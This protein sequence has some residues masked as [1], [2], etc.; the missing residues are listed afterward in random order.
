MNAHSHRFF[1]LSLLSAAL[2]CAA[3]QATPPVKMDKGGKPPVAAKAAA[4]AEKPQFV[5]ELGG[6]RE[7]RLA[8]GLQILLFP[9]QAQ[10]TTTVN[11]TYRV[12]SRH[13]SQG[14]YGMAHLLEHLV[15]KGTPKTPKPD[16]AFKDRAMRTNGTTTVDRTN[17]FA[18]FNA[19]EQTLDWALGFEA[20]RMVNSF[21]A[22]ADLDSEMTVV[23]NEYENGENDPMGVLSRRV[24]AVANDWHPY[25]HSTI[26]PKSDIENVPIERLQGFYK[27]YYRP[28]NATLLV[29]GRFEVDKVLASIVRA[30][31][32]LVRPAAQLVE[33]YTA[34]PPQDGER[35]VVVRRV[36]GQPMLMAS[37]H[38]PSIAHPDSA[39]L[40]VL[41]L[42]MSMQPS[43]HLYKELVETKLAVGAG[44]GGLGGAAPGSTQA[45]AALAP[46]ADAAEVERKLLDLVE[47]RSGKPFE[48]SELE[49][50]REI[51]V[52]SYRQQMKHPEALIQQISSLLGAG[53]W[54]L[55]FQL[56]EDIPKVSLEDVE[57]VRQAYFKPANRTLGRYLPATEVERVAIP[58]APPLAERLSKLQGPPKVEEG[59]RFDPTVQN[60]QAR[61]KVSRLP[62]GLVLSQLAKQTRGN[63][64]QLQMK[65]RWGEPRA[66]TAAL[67]TGMID[68]LMDEGSASWDKQKLR[69]ELV[70]LKAGLDIRGGNQ[71]ATVSISAEKDTL[72][73][74]LKIAADVLQKPLLPPDAFDRIK[75]QGL[76]QMEASRQELELLRSEATRAHANQARGAVKGDPD[77][78]ASLDEQIDELKRTQL[79][80]VQRFWTE[81]WSADDA[82]IAVV[83]A[84]PAGLEAALEQAFGG[85]KKPQAP[86]YVRH[87]SKAVA[88]PPARFDVQAKDKTSAIFRMTQRFELSGQ[89]AD[90]LPMLV[91][92]QVFG[93]G[94]L[95]SRLSDRVRQKE[96]LTYGIGAS[97]QAPYFGRDGGLGIGGTFAPQNRERILAVV[98]EELVRMSRDGITEL[99]L[100][101][102]RKDLLESWR[103]ARAGEASLATSLNWFAE[104]AKDWLGYDGAL[105]AQLQKLSVAQVNA[106]WRRLVKADAFVTSTAGDFAAK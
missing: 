102:A 44:L 89:D 13:E 64:V 36:G 43:G 3:A 76:A 71:G 56:V 8:N 21:I 72:L 69:D 62:S 26:G 83:G 33:P 1:R 34:E 52:V 105:E 17:Y 63:Q 35:S 94:G 54:R 32:P 73:A 60:L 6:I 106:A 4:K 7:Y 10:S 96:G 42:L 65:L 78:L 23:R 28:D 66:T 99:E 59:E 41:S 57:R 103:Q 97:L 91:A 50:V 47:G 95:D 12:G 55:L 58:P 101:R 84:I 77:Y 74:V 98:Q 87:V 82:R 15:F 49:R 24:M 45:M 2:V 9:D 39:P 18:S 92:V 67:G 68:E 86:R 61:T 53:D 31:G 30:F 25:G 37:Y 79:A 46:G 70:K 11:I 14:E 5:R 80:D 40:L 27:R 16:Q 29:A 20:D 19:N 93:A 81:Y 51:A 48:Q 22:K 38:V 85:W 104:I 75:K 100:T 90:Y 88:L